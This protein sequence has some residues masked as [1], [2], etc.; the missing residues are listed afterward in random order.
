M[1]I[2]HCSLHI[3]INIITIY[4]HILSYQKSYLVFAIHK[5]CYYRLA[6]RKKKRNHKITHIVKVGFVVLFM[7]FSVFG[8][9]WNITSILHQTT[10]H[11]LNR[12]RLNDEI[13]VLRLRSLSISLLSFFE[14]QKCTNWIFVP[15]RRI[16]NLPKIANVLLFINI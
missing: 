9:V 2:A 1:L 5:S 12:F 6:D 7:T 10:K 3:V 11:W 15:F 14:P 16:R 4:P 8:K 13:F